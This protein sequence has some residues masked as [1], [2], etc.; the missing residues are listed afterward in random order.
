LWN[1]FWSAGWS[2]RRLILAGIAF[3][4]CATVV[5]WQ[6]MIPLILVAGLVAVFLRYSRDKDAL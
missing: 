1:S 4:I 3:I 6:F 2:E 5:F